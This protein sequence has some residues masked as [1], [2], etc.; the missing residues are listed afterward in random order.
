MKPVLSLIA[1]FFIAQT[2]LLGQAN[3]PLQLSY[4]LAK[5]TAET[6]LERKHADEATNI[7]A[8]QLAQ[9]AAS[10]GSKYST[11]S[12]QPVLSL[13]EEG[14]IEGIKTLI[15][16]KLNV[17]VRVVN[18]ISTETLGAF[19]VVLTGSGANRSEAITKA[20][21]QLRNKKALISKELLGFDQN[22]RAYYDKN[23]DAIAAKANAL[24]SKNEFAA[25]LALL[26]GIPADVACFQTQAALTNQ[27]FTTIQTQQCSTV[28]R[29]ADAFVAANN[30]VA[31]LNVLSQVDPAA[32]CATEASAKIT[33]IEAKVDA[34][35]KEQ[36]EWL[37]KFWSAGVDAEKARWNAITAISLGWLRT[38]SQLELIEK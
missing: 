20:I 18:L 8:T 33:A 9:N 30:F 15:T 17:N 36:W 19:E 26:H 23:C 13:L 32:P 37:F 10:A 25:A 34:A 31:A 24:V 16:A 5:A 22:I 2:L 14:K 11:F 28:L 35:Q 29:Q 38:N 4:L 27:V 1:L 3:T 7:L 12:L 6:P 21:Q